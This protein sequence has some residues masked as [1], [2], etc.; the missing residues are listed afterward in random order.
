MW[1]AHSHR[2]RGHGV[3]PRSDSAKLWSD[4]DVMMAWWGDISWAL[5]MMIGEEKRSTV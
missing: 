5:E 2:V 1:T 3:I 4:H